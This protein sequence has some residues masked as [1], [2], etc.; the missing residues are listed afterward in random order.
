MVKSLNSNLK[1]WMS[2]RLYNFSL[3]KRSKS[4]SFGKIIVFFLSSLEFNKTY[5]IIEQT[6]KDTMKKKFR[7]K[8][9]E[10]LGLPN[11]QGDLAEPSSNK[12]FTIS[13]AYF[14]I[15]VSNPTLKCKIFSI[16][17]VELFLG[18]VSSILNFFRDRM[19]IFK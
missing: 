6:Y 3:F 2:G 18:L 14:K 19:N 1:I 4:S 11:L 8:G 7:L 13:C 10:I 5:G 17:Y 15:L 9:A 16:D 12:G